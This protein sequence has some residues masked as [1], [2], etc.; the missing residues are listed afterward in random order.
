MRH[1]RRR[2][3]RYVNTFSLIF[4][5]YWIV[6]I[7]HWIACGWLSIRGFDQT[8]PILDSYLKSIYWAVTTITTIGYGDIVPESN[9]QIL[10]TMFVEI[11]GVGTYGYLI[12]KMA[13]FSG[14]PR[15]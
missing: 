8:E 12:G 11:V 2:E 13:S 4:F 7:A 3:I 14:R 9:S 1:I 6:H 10:F 15:G 5:I